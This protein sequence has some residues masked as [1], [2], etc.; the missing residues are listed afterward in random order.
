MLQR[1]VLVLI[2]LWSVSLLAQQWRTEPISAIDQQY[3][4]NQLDSVDSLARRYLGR[5]L[6]GQKSNDLAVLQLLLD[7]ELVKADQVVQLQ[8]MGIVLGRLL[9]EQKGLNWVIYVDKL[10]RSR[11]LQVVGIKEFIFPATQI[12]RRAEVG[13]KVDVAKVYTELEQAVIDIRNKPEFF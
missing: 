5:Q 1:I 10:G 12:S 8:A 2:S 3:I 13:L 4:S 9:K 7:K 6:N 11:A